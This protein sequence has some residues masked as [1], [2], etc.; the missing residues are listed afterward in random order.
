MPK[1][2]DSGILPDSQIAKMIDCSRLFSLHKPIE[3]T[4]VQPASI[5][6]RLGKYAYEIK[7]SFLPGEDNLVADKL[8]K[9]DNDF[10]N[11]KIDLQ[12]G[13]V[14]QKGKIYLVKLQESL[15]LED[16][17]CA[18]ANPKS[19]TGRLDIL[20]RLVADNA[21][22]FD[23]LNEG[24]AGD[25]YIEVAP[26]SFNVKL[27]TDSKLNQLRFRKN[28]N[29]SDARISPVLW[30]SLLETKQIS[31][32]YDKTKFNVNNCGLLPF[33]VDLKSND[34]SK[35]IGYCSKS[36]DQII[37]FEARGYKNAD[38]WQPIYANDKNSLILEPNNFYILM[39][40]EAVAIPPEFAAEMVP[41]DTR[42]GEFRVHYAGF[43]DPGFGYCPINREIL[44]SRAVLEIRSHEVPF[45]L[46]HGQI[47]GWL[48]FEKMIN[49]PEKLYGTDVKS[50]YQGQKL[51]LSKHFSGC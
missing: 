46:E 50:N 16:N 51:K 48:R 6:L 2:N 38:F 26:K 13:A 28:S 9:F 7:A 32:K 20:T 33:S 21:N 34:D 22:V 36:T 12:K 11:K 10:E 17:V 14:L 5:D 4:Q 3:S 37:D 24:Y 29:H 43:F 41:Y 15:K 35:I 40:Q 49:A 31:S 19:S 45:L 42:A 44:Q 39:T 8:K 30:E 23:H 18:F 1:I 25:L 27:H 47:A